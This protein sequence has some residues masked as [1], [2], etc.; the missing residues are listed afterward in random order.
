MNRLETSATPEQLTSDRSAR[1]RNTRKIMRLLGDI[2]FLRST[3]KVTITGLEKV[4]RTGPAIVVFNHMNSIDW[5]VA[6][7]SIRFRD[8]VAMGKQEL[9]DNPITWLGFWAWGAIPVRRGQVDRAALRRAIEVIESKDMLM[10]SPE[11]HRQRGGLRD[12]KEGVIM[13]ALRT[14]ALIVPV[15]VSGTENFLRNLIRLHRTPTTARIG[16]P[17][18]IKEGVTRK[19]YAQAADELMY[20]LALLV[21]PNLRGDYA[22]LSKATT[23]TIEIEE[24]ST[25]LITS[26]DQP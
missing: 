22:D 6:A 17:F 12:P 21:E 8:M 15:G 18:R 5:I 13:L 10:I 23:D 25:P 16:D 3:L 14:G 7:C 24:A 1:L 20:R 19:Q 9:Y 26:I 11:G 2:L 4:P